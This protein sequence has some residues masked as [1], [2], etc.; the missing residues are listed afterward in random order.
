MSK[1]ENK[2]LD[3]LEIERLQMEICKIKAE[4]NKLDKERR[5]I[6]KRL[7]SKWYFSNLVLKIIGLFIATILIV[8]SVTSIIIPLTQTSNQLAEY[9]TELA[10]AKREYAYFELNQ[11][12]NKFQEIVLQ[13]RN[14]LQKNKKRQ[15]AILDSLTRQVEKEKAKSHIDSKEIKRMELKIDNLNKQINETESSK[16]F[17]EKILHDTTQVRINIYGFTFQTPQ[18][19]VFIDGELVGHAIKQNF[20]INVFEGIHQLKVQYNDKANRTW[21]YV[22]T[23]NVKKA[24][25]EIIIEKSDFSLKK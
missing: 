10:N 13:Y 15:K 9:K 11:A 4:T 21:E 17:V 19:K 24:T 7:N 20:V 16:K 14:E 12:K 8:A 6:E 23:I 1:Q 5:E 3:D 22:D 18:F 25:D 2:T